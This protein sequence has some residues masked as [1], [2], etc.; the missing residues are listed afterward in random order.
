[1]AGT[2]VSFIADPKLAARVKE[3]ARSDGVT[4]SQA[5]ARAAAL[6]ALLSPAAR[7]TLRFVL[8]QG[9]EDARNAVEASATW[10]IVGDLPYAVL[11]GGARP[12]IDFEDQA[13]LDMAVAGGA[14]MLLTNT[15]ADFTPGARAGIDA[16]VMRRDSAG[17]ADVLLFRHPRLPHG[18]VVA[19]VFAARAWLHYGE[20]PPGGVLGRFLPRET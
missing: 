2:T 19:S 16:D 11:G 1:M 7:R 6:G 3:I 9:G 12:L 18:L 4:Q 14:D 8:D 17:Q 10:G 5:A 20:T 15:M 13:V